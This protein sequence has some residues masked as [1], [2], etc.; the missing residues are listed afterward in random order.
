[1][2]VKKHQKI[3]NAIARGGKLESSPS[4]QKAKASV[5]PESVKVRIIMKRDYKFMKLQR[6]HGSEH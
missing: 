6:L 1:M 2:N 3:R 4:T 5:S